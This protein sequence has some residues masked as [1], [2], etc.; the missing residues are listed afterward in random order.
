MKTLKQ[1][2]KDYNSRKHEDQNVSYA[3]YCDDLYFLVA[4]EKKIKFVNDILK[5]TY[6]QYVKNNPNLLTEEQINYIIKVTGMKKVM[7]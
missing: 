2:T 3:L 4:Q 7:P 5:T 1:I 6:E